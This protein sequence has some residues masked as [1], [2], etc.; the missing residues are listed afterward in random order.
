M[1]FVVIACCVARLRFGCPS[2]VLAIKRRCCDRRMLPQLPYAT[3][4][5]QGPSILVQ[6]AMSGGQRRTF[7]NGVR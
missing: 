1:Q 7:S 5:V 6:C 3:L 2:K 4:A